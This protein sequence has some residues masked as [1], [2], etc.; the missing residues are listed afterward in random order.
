MNEP[1]PARAA[2]IL[3]VD[4]EPDNRTLLEVILAREG[5]KTTSA[6]SGPEALSSLADAAPDLH[7]H[8][9]MTPGMDG[10]EVTARVKGDAR[11]KD[12][13][14]LIISASIDYRTAARAR[15]EGADEFM[16]KPI[17]RVALCE[18]VKRLLHPV[19][20]DQ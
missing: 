17:S 8:D 3:I 1:V 13:P 5:Y 6:A 10:Y 20:G 15:R 11:T 18:Q 14:I 19:A 16:C 9:L 4:D 12:S 7:L 2:Q